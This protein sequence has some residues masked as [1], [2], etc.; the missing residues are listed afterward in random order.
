M[1]QI[2][3]SQFPAPAVLETLSYESIFAEITNQFLDQFPEGRN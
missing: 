2:D 3:L 1:T